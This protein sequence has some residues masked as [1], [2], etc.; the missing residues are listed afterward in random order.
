MDINDE[1][2]K[3]K[4]ITKFFLKL[5]SQK[6]LNIIHIIVIYIILILYINKIILIII[7]FSITVL[8][9]HC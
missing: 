9:K 2:Y 7:Y 1:S 8:M 6:N 5:I 3:G 4:N